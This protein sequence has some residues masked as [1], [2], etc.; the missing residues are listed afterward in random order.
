MSFFKGNS[1]RPAFALRRESHKVKNKDKYKARSARA[2]E[3]IY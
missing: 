1:R 2:D 3:Q